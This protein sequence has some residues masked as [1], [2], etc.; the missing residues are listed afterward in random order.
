LL[1]TDGS[2]NGLLTGDFGKNFNGCHNWLLNLNVIEF[3][4]LCEKEKASI[5]LVCPSLLAA[6]ATN[7]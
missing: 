2:I 3:L 1:A 5:R 4:R 7:S 6:H